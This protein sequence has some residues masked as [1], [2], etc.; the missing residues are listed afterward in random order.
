MDILFRALKFFR[1]DLMR[2]VA[3]LGLTVLSIA[4]NVLKPWPLAIIVDSVLGS[5]PF[6][7]AVPGLIKS[8]E[9]PA[10]LGVLI[11]ALLLVHLAHASLSAIYNY[12]SISV[13]LRGLRR[14]R[15]EV[16][17]WLQRLSLRF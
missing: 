11:A 16:F 12:T 17:G 2:V 4:L 10:Q 9:P 15:N 6:P 3:I 14:V 5:K 8:S 7:Q 13:G 1:P